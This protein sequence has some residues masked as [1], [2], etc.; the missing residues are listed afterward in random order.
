MDGHS[1]SDGSNK[2]SILIQKWMDFDALAL[3]F[4]CDF[5]N[6]ILIEFKTLNLIA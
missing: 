6:F 2:V 3:I 4:S 1:L 5:V